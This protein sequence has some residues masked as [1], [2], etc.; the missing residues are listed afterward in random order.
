MRAQVTQTINSVIVNEFSNQFDYKNI[1]DIEK[2]RDG[3]IVLLRANTMSLNKIACD[4]ALES[5]KQIRKIGDLGIKIPLGYIFK[6]NIIAYFGPN[7]SIKM[8][9]IGYIETK[10][11][12]NFE[13][14]GINQTRHK[15]YVQVN[16]NIRIFVPLHSYDSQVKNEIPICETIIV[17]RIPNTAIN[18][19]LQNAGY[20]L[21]NSGTKIGN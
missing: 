1:I 3:N 9:P 11:I 18:L 12:S 17:G 10:Y 20:K 21:N 13:S 15:I 4:V 19:D 7:I 6:N 14:A 5:Q 8:R 16:T 2:D